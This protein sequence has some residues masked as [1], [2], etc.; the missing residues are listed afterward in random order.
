VRGL[1]RSDDRTAETFNRLIVT[2]KM[3]GVN[4]DRSFANALLSM[5]E[6]HRE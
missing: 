6:G 2:C 5:R 3:R 1:G 4:P